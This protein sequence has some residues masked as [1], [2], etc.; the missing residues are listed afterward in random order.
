MKKPLIFTFLFI[1]I[2]T[3]TSILQAQDANEKARSQ[4]P[5]ADKSLI[6]VLRPSGAAFAIR[7]PVDV[8]EKAI[9]TLGARDFGF[10]NIEPGKHSFKVVNG[11]SKASLFDL[12]TEPGKVYFLQM[13]M[14]MG[15]ISARGVLKSITEAEGAKLIKKCELAGNNQEK[16]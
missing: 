9:A 1:L 15:A 4:T 14:K 12:T 3:A 11:T 10:I 2:F 16:Q 13:D 7:L 6:F 8:D 5:K